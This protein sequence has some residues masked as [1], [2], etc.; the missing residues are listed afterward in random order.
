MGD[1]YQG[2]GNIPELNDNPLEEAIKRRAMRIAHHSTL[3]YLHT[4]QIIN[5]LAADMS[6]AGIPTDY[7]I[8]ALNKGEN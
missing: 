3:T 4:L 1:W 5:D 6:A 8:K 2:W 7:I